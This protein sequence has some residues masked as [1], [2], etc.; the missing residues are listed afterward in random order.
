[1]RMT[2]VE[3][4]KQLVLEAFKNFE[5]V[6]QIDHTYELGYRWLKCDYP[7]QE[8]LQIM[9]LHNEPPVLIYSFLLPESYLQTTIFEEIRRYDS[10]Y[11]L[12]LAILNNKLWLNA[13]VST[14]ILHDS[15]MGFIH[16][17]RGQL[18]NI[19]DC[20]IQLQENLSKCPI[21]EFHI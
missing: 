6:W 20:T 5:P 1:M 14:E 17:A 11:A 15:I 4:Y 10:E 8:Q 21:N 19:I 9:E 16:Q 13:S 18:M 2:L 3:F 12:S 7:I